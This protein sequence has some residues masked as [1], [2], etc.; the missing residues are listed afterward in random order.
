MAEQLIEE[1]AKV[2]LAEGL[3]MELA[4]L[5]EIFSTR[6]AYEGL[7]SL[8]KRRPEFQGA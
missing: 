6:D 4:R 3:S 2:P 1:G 7:S 8:G 5:E